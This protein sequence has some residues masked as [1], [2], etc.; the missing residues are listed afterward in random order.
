MAEKHLKKCSTSLVIREME[1]KMTQRFHFTPIR[2]A[3]IKNASDGRCW[4]GCGKRG[5]LLHCWW[6]CKLVKPLWKSVRQF[7]SKLDILLP[8]D[9]AI[10]FLG[11]YP[12]DAQHIA[13]THA[14]P[15]S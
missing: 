1:I 12:K 14:P 3:K 6:E 7:L 5:T 4:R 13:R 2:M 15:C 8:E 10:P 11:I 9:P